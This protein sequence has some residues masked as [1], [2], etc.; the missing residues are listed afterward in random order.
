MLLEYTIRLLSYTVGTALAVFLLLTALGKRSVKLADRILVLSLAAAA[1]WFGAQALDIYFPMTVALGDSGLRAMLQEVQSWAGLLLAASV[2][3]LTLLWAGAPWWAGLAGYLGAA[4]AK[5]LAESGLLAATWVFAGLCLIAA[6]AAA[7]RASAR[8]TGFS[9]RYL[10]AAALWLILAAAAGGARGGES[11]L[12]ALA[13]TGPLLWT[14]S[15]VYRYNLFDL[16]IS[17]RITFI[18]ALTLV[19]AFYLFLVRRIADFAEVR[20]EAFGAVVQISLIFAVAVLWLPLYEWITRF[21][22]RRS[23]RYTDYS[24][25]V[26]ER[27][28][29][30]LE[31]R[32][33]IQFLA[34]E[35]GKLFQFRR[36]LLYQSAPPRQYGAY[37]CQ[38]PAEALQDIDRLLEAAAAS[39]RP[40]F[41]HVAG[42]K[43]PTQR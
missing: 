2:L 6:A 17:R 40:E 33:R 1:V 14:A 23:I 21:L 37:G 29:P 4:L 16:L 41:L 34:E 18:F 35:V 27:A 32:Q 36:V 28:V 25:Q 20:F 5:W 3:H 10:R 15:Y 26:I 13:A 39:A 12:F 19:S 9:R 38:V 22:S 42:S 30:A 8:E 24:K 31:V 43:D 11:S 7:F